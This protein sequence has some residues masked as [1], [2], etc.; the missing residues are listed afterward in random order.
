MEIASVRSKRAS[1]A[2]PDWLW[3]A[4]EEAEEETTKGGIDAAGCEWEELSV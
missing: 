4:V 1:R 3:D 2:A